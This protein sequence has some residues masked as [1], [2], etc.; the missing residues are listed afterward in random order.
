M[1]TKEHRGQLERLD[2]LVW[3]SLALLVSKEILGLR[4]QL[5]SPGAPVLLVLKESLEPRGS[6]V[7]KG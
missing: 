5:E 3:D 4:G 7:P 6:L 2:Q 1:G